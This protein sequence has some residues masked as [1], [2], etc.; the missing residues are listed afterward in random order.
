MGIHTPPP[1]AAFLTVAFII[2]LFRRDI[3]ERPDVTSAVWVPTLWILILCSRPVSGWLMFFGLPVAPSSAAASVEDSSPI[4]ALV[5][6]ALIGMGMYIL[7]KR[8][9][10]LSELFRHNGW[11]AAFLVYCFIAIVWSDFPLTALK[12]WIKILGPPTMALVIITEPNFPVALMTV[13]KR[14]AYVIV[15]VSL[16]FI[17][18][19]PEFGINYDEWTGMPVSTGISTNKNTLGCDCL[20]LG[21]F[22]FW[23]FLQ[24]WRTERGTSRR[25][26]LLLT[27]G[28]LYMI[29]WL[30]SM[31]HSSTSLTC[32][33]L[34]MLII[35]L[36]ARPRIRR[37][38]TLYVVI[39]IGVITVAEQ[40][41]GISRYFLSFLHRDP[42]L[43]ERTI[44]WSSLFKIKINPIFGAGFE[45]FWLGERLKTLWAMYP[46]LQPNEAHNGYLE[47]YLNLG[48][49]GLCLLIGLLIATFRKARLDLLQN[50]QFARLR[51]GVLAAV[52]AY[53]WT[54]VSFRGP[55]AL[56]LV[57]YI[58]AIEY[59]KLHG[60]FTE[61]DLDPQLSEEPEPIYAEEEITRGAT[62][63]P[64]SIGRS[65]RLVW[66]KH[67]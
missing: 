66:H 60:D 1:I 52:I 53:N 51:L 50:F 19:Y 40:A 44:L 62:S 63:D 67:C 33:L 32:L 34:G 48:V 36:A 7:N 17:K 29:W 31:A 3:R 15:P 38:F 24:T 18:Y 4:D 37:N 9:V 47:T 58:I 6:F 16:L 20:I 2:F 42:T 55:N 59:P 10:Q 43:T 27:A 11:L 64:I 26:E 8:Q 39:A 35:L 41:F 45:S 46:A 30:R 14:C 49:I 21:L 13:I 57:F 25:K 65:G 12:R 23:H 22:F 5:Y 54:E 28:F 61:S 56:W